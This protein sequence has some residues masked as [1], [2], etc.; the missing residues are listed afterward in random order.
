MSLKIRIK[1]F[2]GLTLTIAILIATMADEAM[3]ILDRNA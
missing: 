3:S 1:Y 2:I